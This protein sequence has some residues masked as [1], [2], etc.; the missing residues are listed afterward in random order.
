MDPD[1]ALKRLRE[2]ASMAEFGDMLFPAEEFARQFTALDDWLSK[3]GFPPE[4]WKHG[5]GNDGNPNP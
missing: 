5:T 3:G 2:M 1:E 4:D